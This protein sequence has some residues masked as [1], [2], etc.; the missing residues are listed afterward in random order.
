MKRCRKCD[1]HKPATDFRLNAK[2]RDGLDSWCRECH[3][4]AVHLS[5]AKYGARYNAAKRGRLEQRGLAAVLRGDPSARDYL[6]GVMGDPC[7]YCGGPAAEA[8]HVTPV[9]LGGTE[10]WDNI[11]AACRSCNNRKQ[12]ASVLAW[13]LR[14]LILADRQAIEAEWVAYGTIGRA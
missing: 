13:M 6:Q 5:K 14:R 11:A 3:R 1:E 4:K 2:M 7:A 9:R 8:D 10:T 12:N